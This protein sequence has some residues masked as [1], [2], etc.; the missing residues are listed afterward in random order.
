MRFSWPGFWNRWWTLAGVIAAYA[1]AVVV[2]DK[3]GVFRAVETRLMNAAA[4]EHGS[5][6]VLIVFAIVVSLVGLF[7]LW[8]G[9][10]RIYRMSERTEA[11]T[12]AAYLEAKRALE[13]HRS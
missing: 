1:M 13:Q 6:I 2:L 4:T 7:P 12:A 11:L 8:Y 9:L 10:Y 5:I 3:L